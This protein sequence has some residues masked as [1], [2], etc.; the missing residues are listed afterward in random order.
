MVS[1]ERVISFAA[2]LWVSAQLIELAQNQAVRKVLVRQGNSTRRATLVCMSAIIT[3]TGLTN[4]VSG[5]DFYSRSLV[6]LEF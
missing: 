1:N 6:L 5:V 2:E 3:S 4:P